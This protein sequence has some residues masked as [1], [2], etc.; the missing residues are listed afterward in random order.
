[1]RKGDIERRL[2]F[3]KVGNK[4]GRHEE[5]YLWWALGDECPQCRNYYWYLP[6]K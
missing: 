2:A 4:I 3:Y 5:T 1:M 6:T